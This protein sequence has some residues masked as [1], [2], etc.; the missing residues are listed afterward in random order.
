MTIDHITLICLLGM[1]RSPGTPRTKGIKRRTRECALLWLVFA[2]FV[3]CCFH[4]RLFESEPALRFVV[5]FLLGISRI[6]RS[7]G[8]KWQRWETG[9]YIH[10][11]IKYRERPWSSHFPNFCESFIWP[12]R[13]KCPNYATILS[14][15]CIVIVG[16]PRVACKPSPLWFNA[17]SFFVQTLLELHFLLP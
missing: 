13:N 11:I 16:L 4:F 6:C 1:A 8:L 2:F 15:Y 17:L 10:L 3:L 5:S 7:C 14:I 12:Q 9:L